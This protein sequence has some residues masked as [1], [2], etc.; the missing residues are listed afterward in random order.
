M[1]GN[2]FG[3]RMAKPA[4][5]VGFLWKG[6]VMNGMYIVFWAQAIYLTILGLMFVFF[7]SLAEFIFKTELKDPILTP[8]FGQVLLTLAL[9]S[10]LIIR[11]LDNY[12]KLIWVLIF[13]NAGHIVVFAYVLIAGTVG[14][15][16]VGPPLII[17][18]IFLV[19]FFVYYFRFRSEYP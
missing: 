13:E 17:S 19:L 18:A 8:L 9:A 14:F 3:E 15:G 10:Y 2:I 6:E 1:Q 12:F 5:V 7:P 11:N 4:C 16:T